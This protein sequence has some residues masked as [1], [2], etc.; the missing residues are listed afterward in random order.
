MPSHPEAS[1]SLFPEGWEDE[2]EAL[3]LVLSADTE[4]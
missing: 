3:A 4:E 1:L 2:V